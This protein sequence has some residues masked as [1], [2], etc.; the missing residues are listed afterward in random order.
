MY[1]FEDISYSHIDLGVLVYTELKLYKHIQ[2]V[3]HKAGSQAHSF[4]K[5]TVCHSPAFMLFLLTTHICPII[6]YY[7]LFLPMEHLSDM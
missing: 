3:V 7:L 2:T 5:S 6:E 1:N 4:L